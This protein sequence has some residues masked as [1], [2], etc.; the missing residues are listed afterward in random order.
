MMGS[1]RWRKDSLALFTGK[2]KKQWVGWEQKASGTPQKSLNDKSLWPKETKA[3]GEKT[4]RFYQSGNVPD[5]PGISSFTTK[6]ESYH[7]YW[8]YAK[9]KWKSTLR[10]SQSQI[11]VIWD[12]WLQWVETNQI[13]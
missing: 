10:G 1:R 8:Y 2:A 11:R 12:Q 3:I 6:H 5:E 7:R 13:C 4:D 9:K